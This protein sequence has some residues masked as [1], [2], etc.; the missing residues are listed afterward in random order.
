MTDRAKIANV[1]SML[2]QK[3][4]KARRRVAKGGRELVPT[5]RRVGGSNQLRAA[6]D[7]VSIA[8]RARAELANMEE[9][10]LFSDRQLELLGIVHPRSKDRALVDA[11]SQLGAATARRLDQDGAGF[12][13]DLSDLIRRAAV[14]DYHLADQPV[15]RALHQRRQRRHQ[16][17]RGVQGGDDDREGR[18]HRAAARMASTWAAVEFT[19]AK[20]SA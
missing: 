1:R 11:R 12:L 18:A 13:G 5:G 9:A 10:K 17:I 7:S 19:K 14:G 4:G 2:D 3:Q 8:D 20:P 15:R 6:N 16:G